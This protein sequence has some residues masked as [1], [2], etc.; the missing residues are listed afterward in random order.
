MPYNR[1]LMGQLRLHHLKGFSMSDNS[2]YQGHLADGSSVQK[3]SV[4]SLYPCVLFK[5]YGMF[6]II[7]PSDQHGKLYDSYDLAVKAGLAWKAKH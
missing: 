6:G 3:H 1:A 7:T 5:K 2:I 4:G